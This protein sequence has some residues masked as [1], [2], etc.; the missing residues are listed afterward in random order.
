MIVCLV[1]AHTTHTRTGGDYVDQDRHGGV[2]DCCYTGAPVIHHRLRE[3][4]PDLVVER[5]RHHD[6][7]DDGQPTTRHQRDRATWADGPAGLLELGITAQR[8]R[9]LRQMAFQIWGW[10]AVKN[11]PGEDQICPKY[12]FTKHFSPSR[13]PFQWLRPPKGVSN[14]DLRHSIVTLY[15][16]TSSPSKIVRGKCY[17]H[18]ESSRNCFLKGLAKVPR[19]DLAISYRQPTHFIMGCT[20]GGIWHPH[21][22]VWAVLAIAMCFCPLA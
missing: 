16:Q 19:S 5:Y 11:H 13:W 20:D 4:T 6:Q 1:A 15:F 3:Q 22:F 2:F 21:G 12:G 9:L 10:R 8:R 18:I 7:L 17:F 14:S